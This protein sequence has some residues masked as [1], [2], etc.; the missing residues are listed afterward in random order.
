M[1]WLGFLA[2]CLSFVL[3]VTSWERIVVFL[4]IILVLSLEMINSQVEKILNIVEPNF[5]LKVKEIKDVSAGAVLL[6]SIGALIIGFLIFQPYI[7]AIINSR[8]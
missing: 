3:E 4:M 7:I 8:C 6:A 2:V 5:S 1:L